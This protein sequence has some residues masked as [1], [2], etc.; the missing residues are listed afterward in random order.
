M[1]SRG[2][3]N[4][5]KVLSGLIISSYATLIAVHVT[6]AKGIPCGNPLS[7]DGNFAV[8]QEEENKMFEVAEE[9]DLLILSAIAEEMEIKR[10]PRWHVRF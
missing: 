2:D 1:F 9:E 4:K 3:K 7:G 10:Q 8:I 6:C 5:N